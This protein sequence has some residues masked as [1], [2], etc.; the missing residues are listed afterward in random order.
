MCSSAAPSDE[1]RY[2]TDAAIADVVER[3]SARLSAVPGAR[4]A[5]IATSE[6]GGGGTYYLTKEG[7]TFERP[8]DQ[9]AVRRIAATPEFF[10]VVRLAA[11]AGRLFNQGDRAGG[12]PVVV[13]TRDLADKYFPGEN[14]IGKRIR[15]GRNPTFPWRTIVGIVPRL[16]SATDGNTVIETAFVPLA[17]APDRS[18]TLLLS[19][20]DA[21]INAAPGVRK[22]VRDIDQDL[23]VFGLDS[24]ASLIHRRAWPFRVFGTLF[25]TFGLS[26]LIMAAAGLYGVLAFGVR[27]RTQEIGCM[28]LAGRGQVIRMILRQGLV[29]VGVG[30]VAGLGI[31]YLLGPLMQALFF[32]VKATDPLVFA[33]TISLLLLTGFLASFV[34]ARRAASVDP[35]VALREG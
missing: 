2:P 6:P 26:A 30:L 32:N 18:L 28:A 19:A 14:P 35:L 25:M 5:A 13:I 3:L 11:T 7:Q 22:A 15:L 24:F 29:V 33:T 20:G 10:D 4:R 17:Q 31:G 34:P 8:E 12:L 27:L 1:P 9:P 23:P 21:P 16:Q